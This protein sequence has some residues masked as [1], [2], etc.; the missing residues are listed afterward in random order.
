MHLIIWRK[1][2]LRIVEKIEGWWHKREKIE[3]KRERSEGKYKVKGK[4]N[5]TLCGHGR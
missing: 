1:K 3:A 2:G 5:K 4:W